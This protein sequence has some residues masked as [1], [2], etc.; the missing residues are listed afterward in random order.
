MRRNQGYIITHSFRYNA[1][2]ELVLAETETT[3]GT[4]Y[5]T[6]ECIDGNNYF[7]GHYFTDKRKAMI[8]FAVRLAGE[9]GTEIEVLDA[10]L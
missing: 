3:H 2:M 5:V 7:W 10:E 9:F 1:K 4:K 8:D 6:W